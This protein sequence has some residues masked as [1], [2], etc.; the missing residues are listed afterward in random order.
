MMPAGIAQARSEHALTGQ[1]KF[2]FPVQVC[3]LHTK[4]QSAPLP[5]LWQIFTGESQLWTSHR[6]QA[7]QH[8]T[9]RGNY[10][11]WVQT[12]RLLE[13][14]HAPAVLTMS[15]LSH[16][17]SAVA[18]PCSQ[19]PLQLISPQEQTA[20]Q[21][22][23]RRWELAE[24]EEHAAWGMSTLLGS[25]QLPEP[26]ISLGHF[27]LPLGMSV[28]GCCECPSAARPCHSTEQSHPYNPYSAA[29]C[30]PRGCV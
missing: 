25:T 10:H 21:A 14:L 20:R 29:F 6:S 27:P 8:S 16:I 7:P 9:S 23:G 12:C 4:G 17:C 3:I 15:L 11:V 2:P 22:S 1:E 19:S 5:N 26:E 28:Q 24:R 30:G 13:W 18:F